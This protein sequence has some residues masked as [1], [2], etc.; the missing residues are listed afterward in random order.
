M[1][2]YDPTTSVSEATGRQCASAIAIAAAGQSNDEELQTGTSLSK[3]NEPVLLPKGP[4]RVKFKD[5]EAEDGE[6]P[7]EQLWDPLE[8][9]PPEPEQAPSATVIDPTPEPSIGELKNEMLKRGW[10]LHQ[11]EYL[12]QLHELSVLRIFATLDRRKHRPEDHRPCLEQTHCIAY[13]TSKNQHHPTRHTPDCARRNCSTVKVPYKQLV[14]IV[15]SGGVPLVSIRDSPTRGLSFRV[16]RRQFRANYATISHVWADGIASQAENAL[17]ACQVKR[18][19][20]LLDYEIDS[21]PSSWMQRVDETIFR[22]GKIKMLWMDALCIPAQRGHEE[23]RLQCID[24]MASIYAG[25]SRVFVFDKELM[26]IPMPKM[27]QGDLIPLYQIASSVWM[28]RS[29]T[30]QEAILP[31]QCLF[32]FSDGLF[33]P[34]KMKGEYRIWALPNDASLA[35]HAELAEYK[36]GLAIAKTLFDNFLEKRNAVRT[37][38]DVDNFI[39]T[40]NGLAGRSTSKAEDLY[41]VLASCL[42]FKLRQFRRFKTMEEKVQRI[43]FSFQELPLSLFF[44]PGPRLD[45]VG[46]HHNRWVPTQVSRHLLTSGSTIVL[47]SPE[48]SKYSDQGMRL[49]LNPGPELSVFLVDEIILPSK[50][51]VVGTTEKTYQIISVLDPADRFQT[52]GCIATCLIIENDSLGTSASSRG[53]CFYVTTRRDADETEQ[54]QPLFEMIYFCPVMVAAREIQERSTRNA[55]SW[56]IAREVE[57][58]SIFWVRFSMYQTLSSESLSNLLIR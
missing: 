36:T 50:E 17:P 56:Y 11:I 48:I 22:V 14:Q 1:G 6:L 37:L 38:G 7:R 34:N 28:C 40:W 4:K 51:Y 19:Q 33:Q 5:I 8:D 47:P 9:L 39:S 18:L 32:Q 24:A 27:D 25:S 55:D 52:I 54:H 20:S 16:H 35:D 29:W 53:A 13:N 41:V 49:E 26:A 3:P 2:R 21:E 46:N 30:L 23:L 58:S 44:N 12:A 31:Q 43:I 45:A 57:R 15:R 10:C 42:D